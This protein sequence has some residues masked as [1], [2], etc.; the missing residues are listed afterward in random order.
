MQTQSENFNETIE[1]QVQRLLDQ[2]LELQ[3]EEALRDQFY[4]L[5]T[6]T[7]TKD[8]QDEIEPYKPFPRKQYLWEILQVLLNEKELFVEKSRTMMLSW[9][10]S[11]YCAYKMFTSPATG[12]VFQSQDEDRAVH[13]VRCVK[14]LWEN[15]IDPLKKRWPLKKELHTQPHWR[16]DLANGSWC[17]GIPGNPDKIRSEHPSIVVL[18][19][20]AHIE[21]GEQ[22]YN[23]AV[24]TR[25]NQ[26]IANS[27]AKPGW[28]RQ[29]TKYALPVDWPDYG[30][31]RRFRHT[32]EGKKTPL[33]GLSMRRTKSGIAV[34]RVHHIADPDTAQPEW[35]KTQRARYTSEAWWRLEI[36]I[37]YEAQSGQ[38]V[39]PEFDRGVHVIPDSAVPK[40]GCRFMAIDPHPRTPHAFMWVLIDEWSDWYVY[41]E[42]WPSVVCGEAMVLRDDVE[43][44]KYTVREY[45]ETI[46]DLEGNRIEFHRN[47]T[48]SEYGIYR[49]N[50]DGY[51]PD[52]QRNVSELAPDCRRHRGP[53][54]ILARYMDQAGKG[55]IASG[56]HQREETYS[57]RYYRYGIQCLDPVKSHRTGE[58]AIHSLLK[59]R[60]HDLKGN[61]PK[62]HVAAS[63]EETIL[64]FMEHRYQRLRVSSANDDKELKQEGVQAR[65]HMLDLL[66]YLATANIQHNPNHIS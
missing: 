60:G 41:R 24:A 16:L 15:S 4:W 64:E 12:I 1:L 18:D 25:C 20:A 10:I 65:T 37:D 19:E 22:S 7:K 46:A 51:C 62:L 23:V 21:Q 40:R 35:R 26:I 13:D 63:C 33:P 56:E 9:L 14:I 42:L 66:R 52:C 48:D 55:F 34:M 49:R 53:E 17:T 28:F 58:D 45:A 3:A 47:L 30:R 59:P 39:Y 31:G 29:F 6:A 38:R 8:E 50:Y 27:S 44:R 61:W 43:D 36:D 57:D 54:H 32:Y 2:S 11:A 5:T